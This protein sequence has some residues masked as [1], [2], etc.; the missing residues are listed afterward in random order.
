MVD[1]NIPECNFLGG[2][3]KLFFVEHI[4]KS[5]L[6]TCKVVWELNLATDAFNFITV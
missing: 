6:R 4:Q 2:V 3:L 5:H 1:P